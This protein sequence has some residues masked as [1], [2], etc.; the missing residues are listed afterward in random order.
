MEYPYT[1]VAGTKAVANEV[2]SNF[3]T[4]GN[5][6]D[7]NTTN[8]TDLQN[9]KADLS[10]SNL[11]ETGLDAFANKDADNFTTTG[12]TYLSGLGMPSS[13]Y[14][15]LTLGASGTT[16]TAPANGYI[17]LVRTM[18]AAGYQRIT[19]NTVGSEVR[20]HLAAGGLANF[21]PVLKGATVYIT[22]DGT[23]SRSTL[24]FIY[25]EGSPST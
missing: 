8:I 18:T 5:Q 2:N 1:F 20:T 3:E 6:V 22:Y 9:N 15:Y 12:T 14:I 4:V 11:N 13:R 21:L 7:T 19:C 16:Y 24:R 23:F 17:Y 10:L 25:A